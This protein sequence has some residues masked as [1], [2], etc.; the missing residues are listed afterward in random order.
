MN[1]NAGYT[2]DWDAKPNPLFNF[3]TIGNVSEVLPGVVR[4][5]TATFYQQMDSDATR[6]CSE[7][8]DVLD[9]VPSF[10]P[11]TANFIESF[12]GRFALNLAWA[13]AIIATWQ[14]EGPSGLMDQ[15]IT[16]TD[17]ADIKAQAIAD[18]ERAQKVWRRVRRVWGR[19]PR[20]MER[21]RSKAQ[22]LH[23]AEQARDF[24][25]MS[26]RQ[27]WRH[28]L[29][30]R[31]QLAVPYAEHLIVSGAAG[32]HTD[33]LNKLLDRALPGHDPALVVA[34]TS[35]LRDVESA[36][37]AKAI[38][39][40]ATLVR[41]RKSLLAEVT[42]LN[43]A[44][45]AARLRD[46]KG[47]DWKAFRGAFDA[48]VGE[49][50]FRG[51][52]E[53]DP[54][55]AD[56]EE[57]PNFVIGA[58]KAYLTAGEENDPSRLEEQAARAREAIEAQIGPAI[59]R[60]LRGKYRELLAG[61]QK[62]TR[63]RESTKANW[64]RY[65]RILRRPMLELGKRFTA[66]GLL[67]RPDDVF[68]LLE[69]EVAAAVAS[70][71]TASASKEA[72]ARHKKQAALLEGTELPEVFE[73]PITPT[74]IAPAEAASKVYQ[75]MPVSGGKASGPA[76]IIRSAEAAMAAELAPGEVLVAPFTDAPWTPLFVPAAAVVVE[77]G[78]VLSHAATVAR[79]FGI[80]AVVAI[81]GATRLIEDGQTV[82]V[83]GF[84]GTV[85]V[86]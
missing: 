50:G 54:S 34:L 79:E 46:S 15:Y 4:P 16:S 44:E 5:F 58:V 26:E 31:R 70:Q 68:W 22:A 7:W 84:T 85:T 76:R 9:L 27:I 14:V 81:K 42:A 20:T 12:A 41:G 75:G 63:M 13:N 25:A 49:Y 37:P 60:T 28:L 24:A 6:M 3:W 55:A 67:E 78:G 11:P 43:A 74:P 62:F 45:V 19:M 86:G 1:E 59:P 47:A 17:G 53:V 69:A 33:R 35:A 38:W 73:L 23:D 39:R 57:E 72:V 66:R 71:L 30:L 10:P 52:R 51:Q 32:D 77:T 8:V 56:W 82:T 83:D 29:R 61:A 18:P 80:P 36:R 48:L 21:R 65:C 40:V 2:C 64:V